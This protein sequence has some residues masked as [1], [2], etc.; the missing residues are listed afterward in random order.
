MKRLVILFKNRLFLLE[1]FLLVNRLV[2]LFRYFVG[3]EIGDFVLVFDVDDCVQ[4]EDDCKDDG[5]VYFQQGVVQCSEGVGYVFYIICKKDDFRI[6]DRLG[7]FFFD[8]CVINIIMV[9]VIKLGYF[10]Y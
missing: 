2:I 3:E 9:V 1:I 8:L 6:S 5:F 7:F 10:I 4:G